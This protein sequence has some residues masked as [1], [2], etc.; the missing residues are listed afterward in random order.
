[1]SVPRTV[2]DVIRKH[3]TLEVEGIDRM[4]LNVYQPKLQTD[5]GV[6][7]FFRFHREQPVA[8][9][10]LMEPMSNGLHQRTSMP[11]PRSNDVPLVPFEKEQRKDDVA[12]EYRA[13]F[14]EARRRPLPRQGPGKGAGLPHRETDQC[15]HGQEVSLDRQVPRPMVNQ[16]Y[17]YCIDEDF[18][19]FFL[20]FCT[21]FPYNAKLC[22][23]GH[24]YVKRQ[25]A[26]EGIAF[27]ALD[28]GVL[29]CANPQRLQQLCDGLSADQDRR[30]VAQVAGALAASLHR[31]RSQ[32]RLSLRR[33]HPA[34]R[35]LADPSS[36][37]PPDGPH[38][39]RG[40]HPRKPGPGPAR[41]GATDLRPA[42]DQAH[43]GPL[44]H[45]RLDRRRDPVAARGLQ[46]HA[47]QAIPQGRPGLA[48]RDH[49]QQHPRLRH[50]Q[51]A[52]ES[53]RFAG[54]RLSSQPTSVGRPTTQP[55]LH[56]RRR[57]VPAGE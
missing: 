10:A 17:F 53:S 26:K 9:S 22:I 51:A 48:H 7:A 27:E 35:V 18:G 49:H 40:S 23:N 25:L 56:D 6:V 29:S 47:N 15:G 44:S 8:S 42:R 5:S 24:E 20:K 54:D 38:L 1:M 37:P 43:A 52:E 39:L 57:R 36:R 13:R 4:Y 45:A 28:N 34:G 50:R 32:G 30:P 31:R 12:A 14:S 3:V 33:V 2:A 19:P 21:Y 46:E 11:L 16:F 55:R 41:P